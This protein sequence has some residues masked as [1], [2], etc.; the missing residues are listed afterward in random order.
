[1]TTGRYWCID[2]HVSKTK[3][4][5][6]KVGSACVCIIFVAC[7]HEPQDK[8]R[9][10]D[11]MRN[12][13]EAKILGTNGQLSSAT[14]RGQEK[15]SKTPKSPQE[16]LRNISKV[17]LEHEEISQKKTLFSFRLARVVTDCSLL[18]S[19]DVYASEDNKERGWNAE[20][21]RVMLRLVIVCGFIP[22]AGT[23]NGFVPDSHVHNGK[24]KIMHLVR[25]CSIKP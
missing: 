5:K 20:K 4:K 22:A 19:T 10:I 15:Y 25:A 2:T 13:G 23:K 21:R 16:Q 1:M 14:M 3:T 18:F 9:T 6:L 8:G 7:R 17:C 11:K 24:Q 12:G